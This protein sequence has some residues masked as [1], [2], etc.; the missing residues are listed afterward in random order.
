MAHPR[1]LRTLKGFAEPVTAAALSQDGNFAAAVSTD[2]SLRVYP[3]LAREAGAPLPNPL[4]AQIPLDHGVACCF[5][6][7]GKNV[8]VATAQTRRLLA[9][10]TQCVAAPKRLLPTRGGAG[11]SSARPSAAHAPARRRGAGPSSRSSARSPL[12]RSTEAP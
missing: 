1:L 11:Q 9:Y 6:A 8:V 5:A 10:A 3:G 7:T 2:R 4:L 12:R